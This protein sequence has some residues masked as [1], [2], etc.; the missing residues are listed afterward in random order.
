MISEVPSN[1]NHSTSLCSLDFP[2]PSPHEAHIKLNSSKRLLLTLN[3]SAQVIIMWLLP[4]QKQN[5]RTAGNLYLYL[6]VEY[7]M[8]CVTLWSI[9][10][11]HGDHS[12]H[13]S[14]P[15]GAGKMQLNSTSCHGNSYSLCPDSFYFLVH[16]NL[17]ISGQF[18][19]VLPV[20]IKESLQQSSLP[21]H[22]T[23]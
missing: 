16:T 22:F 9:S 8:A 2:F 15:H 12:S 13:G 6:N 1:P 10:A 11:L 14:K 4:S 17:Y 20:R 7:P 21:G 19:W 23:L 3:V 18:K 5:W